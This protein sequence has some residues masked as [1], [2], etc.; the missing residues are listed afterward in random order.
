MRIKTFSLRSKLSTL[1][2]LLLWCVA[3]DKQIPGTGLQK[4]TAVHSAPN[5][6]ETPVEL[7]AGKREDGQ[8]GA[9]VSSEEE[10]A[11]V[12]LHFEDVTARS[13]VQF[14]FSSGRAA[15]EFAIIESLGGGVGLFDYDLD[16]HIDIH[17]AGG[18]TLANRSITSQPCGLFR[19]HGDWNFSDATRGAR[20]DAAEFYT[21]GIFPGDWDNDGFDDVAVSGYGGVQLLHNQGD[22]TF[23][24]LPSQVTHPEHP[25]SSSLSWADFDRNGVLDLYVAHYVDWSWS[26][27]PACPGAVVAREV[28][29]PREFAGVTDAIYYGLGDGSFRRC[30]TEVGLVENGKGLGV[31]AADIDGDRDTDIYVAND[32][33]DNFFYINDG[34]GHFKESAVLA[35]IA[36]DE[37]GVSTGSMGTFVFDADGDGLADV[38]AVN[39]ERELFALYRNET[40]DSFSHVSRAVGLAALE[41][42]YVG[43]GT[44][45]MDFDQDAD[46]DLIVANG[47][48]SYASPHASFKQLPL[49]LENVEGRFSKVV[50][51]D[52]FAQKHTGR[53]LAYG[54]LNN[55]GA[56]DLVVSHLEEPV[57]ILRGSMPAPTTTHLTTQVRLHLIGTVSNRSAIGAVIRLPDG[58][59]VM[60]NGGGSYLSTSES[61]LSLTGIEA[62]KP[63][64][65]EVVWPSGETESWSFAGS[66][67]ELTVIEGQSTKSTSLK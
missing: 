54:D 28:C 5:G 48:V 24:Q 13:G 33:T 59:L 56:L 58:R 43:F 25:W 65:F 35:G 55:D 27:H 45:A 36:G 20:A 19:N 49:L 32:T 6:K 3:C 31:V 44:V 57:A 38:W 66:N 21:H 9:V 60:L 51:A 11:P 39:F 62:G 52:Y 1:C 14:S 16:G 53:G 37:A 34:Q 22:G 17:F 64:S 18:G 29:A 40:G 7:P 61:R 50:S 8:R 10:L 47:H 2:I 12:P 67:R 30:D 46:L 4:Q 42:S 41:G 23:I 15:G 63:I 26:K